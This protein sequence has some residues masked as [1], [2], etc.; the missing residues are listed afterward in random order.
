WGLCGIRGRSY[1]VV[2]A[3][4]GLAPEKISPRLDT[5]VRQ[6]GRTAGHRRQHRRRLPGARRDTART[7]RGRA[8]LR[9]A[10]HP[11]DR[12]DTRVAD[13]SDVALRPGIGGVAGAEA[14]RDSP[15]A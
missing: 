6:R 12:T 15:T 3:V 5:G 11:D 13:C 10:L 2:R 9:L 4:S 1:L 14:R 8:E 7:W